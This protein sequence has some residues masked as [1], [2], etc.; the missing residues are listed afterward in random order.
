VTARGPAVPHADA[1]RMQR[2]KPHA[3]APAA[4]AAGQPASAATRAISVID[5]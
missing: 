2:R 4:A 5:E 3:H 1:G